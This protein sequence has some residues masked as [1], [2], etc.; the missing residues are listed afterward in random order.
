MSYKVSFSSRFFPLLLG[1]RVQSGQ[2]IYFLAAGLPAWNCIWYVFSPYKFSIEYCWPY[3]FLSAISLAQ[4]FRPTLAGWVA[5]FTVYGFTF[6]ALLMELIIELSDYENPDH[7]AF[8][9][10]NDVLLLMGLVV[11]AALVCT[12]VAFHF[13]KDRAHD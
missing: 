2:W 10:W 9:G 13:P 8:P 12:S 6:G 1:T 3:I 11:Y 5:V 4:F 7:G